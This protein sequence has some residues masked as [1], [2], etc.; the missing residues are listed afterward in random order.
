MVG[1]AT[2]YHECFL[3][4][5]TLTTQD[6]FSIVKAEA[7]DYAGNR[8]LVMGDGGKAYPDQ[9]F[10]FSSAELKKTCIQLPAI[11]TIEILT[12][13]RLMQQGR[14]L[15]EITFSSLARAL[16]RR[17]SSLTY[18]YEGVEMGYDFK[19]LSEQSKDIETLESSFAWTKL[20]GDCGGTRLSGVTG[21]ATFSGNL[22]DF[23]IFLLLGQYLNIGKGA[24]FGLGQY[25]IV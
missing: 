9:I 14:P 6:C 18:Y 21:R 24:T 10:I 1:V 3:K 13:M 20:K 19:W 7:V 8:Y 16:F 2:E 5:L 22:D 12:P 4:A 23:Q 11:I 17:V 25:M 15:R